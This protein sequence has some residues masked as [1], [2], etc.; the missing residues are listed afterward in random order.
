MKIEIVNDDR[1]HELYRILKNL[2]YITLK[3][4]Y[5]DY[6]KLKNV[7]NKLLGDIFGTHLKNQEGFYWDEARNGIDNIFSSINIYNNAKAKGA[8]KV[9][10]KAEEIKK[11]ALIDA[12]KKIENLKKFLK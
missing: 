7:Y 10:E 11:G 9:M 1:K 4:R 8:I 6:L 12:L 5:E 3:E 2:Y